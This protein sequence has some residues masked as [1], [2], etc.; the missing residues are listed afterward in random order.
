MDIVLC[1]QFLVAV[2]SLSGSGEAEVAG[3]G[4]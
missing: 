1:V 3:F 2:T 4:V